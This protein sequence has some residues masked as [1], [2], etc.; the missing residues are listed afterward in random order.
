M[1]RIGTET[2]PPLRYDESAVSHWMGGTIPRG[3]VRTC[4]LEALSRRLGR[5]VTHAEAGPPVPRSLVFAAADT[6]GGVIG[7]GRLDMAAAADQHGA[8]HGG[9]PARV[10]CLEPG[11]G[12]VVGAPHHRW[13]G[14]GGLFLTAGP[15]VEVVLQR[16]LT[17][18]DHSTK[19]MLL[20]MFR[21]PGFG[22]G[23]GI[24]F[25]DGAD[26]VEKRPGG[27]VRSV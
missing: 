5:S 27:S 9:Q 6:V 11:P 12:D 8:E 15:R 20:V 10:G 3:T 4:I 23:G 2:K 7:L 16:S 18:R 25:P 26:V 14:A 17:R 22:R 1:N 19:P 13:T 21:C 24:G